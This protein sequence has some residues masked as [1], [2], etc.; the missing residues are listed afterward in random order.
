MRGQAGA[1]LLGGHRGLPLATRRDHAIPDLHPAL[2]QG[3]DVGVVG[4]Q[5]QGVALAVQLLEELQH[6]GACLRVQGARGLIRQQQGRGVGQGPGHGDPLLLT[7]GERRGQLVRLVGDAHLLEQG[8]GPLAALFP[9]HAGVEHGQLHV[10]D[11]AR[12]GQ[13]VVALEHEA[14]LLIADAG[15]LTPAEAL[16]CVPVQGV[17]ARRGQVQAAQDG[18]KRR[19][20]RA[21]GADQGHELARLDAEV[22]A[23]QCVD[24]R[25]VGAIDLGQA[26]GLDDGGPGVPS[27]SHRPS[28]P[29]SCWG[30]RGSPDRRP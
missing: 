13:Q 5:Q 21:G 9:S 18:H 23:A 11:D 28:R 22:H 2:C 15:Q 6:L 25:A 8:Q 19:L 26:Q 14:D 12:L 29:S 20:A 17:G 3:G 30:P 16:D 27:C 4:D 24:G 7:P 10:P 1:R